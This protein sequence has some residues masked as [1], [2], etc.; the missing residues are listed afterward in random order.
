MNRDTHRHKPPQHTDRKRGYTE[1]QKKSLESYTS[2][3]SKE[4]TAG[5]K[6][7]ERPAL[8]WTSEG[9]RRSLTR[10]AYCR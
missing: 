5:L 9:P 1:K 8:G 2:S 3:S 10:V 4:L 6:L 7:L